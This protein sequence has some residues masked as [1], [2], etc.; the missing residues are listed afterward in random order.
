MRGL[1]AIGWF[2]APGEFVDAEEHPEQRNY[3]LDIAWNMRY[4]NE[5]LSKYSDF[6]TT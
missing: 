1:E 3:A 6:F 4:G 2:D 5:V